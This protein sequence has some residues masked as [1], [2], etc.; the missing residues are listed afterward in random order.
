MRQRDA[1]GEAAEHTRSNQNYSENFRIFRIVKDTLSLILKI[2]PLTL[3][4]TFQSSL[5]LPKAVLE[6]SLCLFLVFV[7][8]GAGVLW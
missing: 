6:V 3:K 1:K 7:G 2:F 4:T 8:S 5:P